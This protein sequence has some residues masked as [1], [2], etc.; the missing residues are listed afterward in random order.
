MKYKYT[1]LFLI[2]IYGSNKAQ[3]IDSKF[4][5][6]NA[7]KSYDIGD[8]ASSIEKYNS[9]N[10]LDTS[11]NMSMFNAGNASFM[12]GE[13]EEA[14]SYYENYINKS[15]SDTEKAEA[16]YNM[17]NSYFNDYKKNNNQES[18]TK[19]IESY[20]QSLRLNPKDADTRYNLSKAMKIA[21]Q[22]QENQD[23]ENKDQD[24]QDQDNQ[25]QQNKDQENQDQENKS[26]KDKDQENKDQKDKKQEENQKENN[27]NNPQKE[28]QQ[29][30]TMGQEQALKNLDAINSDEEKVLLKVNRKKGDEKKASKT[31]DW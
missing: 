31:K 28:R 20:K 13:F 15:K 30:P 26:Q 8:Y 14:N 17:G 23:Q 11:N 10:K 7:N 22:Q 1:L 3:N 2:L 18:L 24:N 6:S 29:K 12:K 16:L 25:D 27:K 19:S 9:A 21:M 5:L 4:A